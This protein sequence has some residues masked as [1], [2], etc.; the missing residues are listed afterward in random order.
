[1]ARHLFAALAVELALAGILEIIL[2]VRASNA[3]ALGL[4]RLLGFAETGRRP[5]Y[6]HD[7]VEDAVLMRLK[8]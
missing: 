2:E 6:Y 1:L 7:P 5:R 8:F 4:Y 3:A